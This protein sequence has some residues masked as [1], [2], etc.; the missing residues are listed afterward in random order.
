MNKERRKRLTDSIDKI[1]AV[2]DSIDSVKFQEEDALDN[3]PENFQ[4]T[5]RYLDA[6]EKIDSLEGALSDLTSAIRNLEKAI[7]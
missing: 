5:D 6:E 1:A 3:L 4:G 7:S 2:K